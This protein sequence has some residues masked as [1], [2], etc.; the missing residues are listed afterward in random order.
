MASETNGNILVTSS[1]EDPTR[2][3]TY[4]GSTVVCDSSGSFGAD[5]SWVRF[6]GAAGTMLANAA[7]PAYACGTHA[8]GRYTG[9]YPSIGQFS[10]GSVCFHSSVNI[11]HRSTQI[12]VGHC[13]SFHI[14]S[15]GSAPKY[16]LRYCTV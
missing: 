8:T 3:A 15:L 9:H 12:S 7:V 11:C 6:S 4:T 5:P 10:I 13:N 16:S 14:Y 2:R 1:T